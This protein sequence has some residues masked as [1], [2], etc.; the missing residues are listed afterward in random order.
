MPKQG[1]SKANEAHKKSVKIP[2]G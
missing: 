2:K 1:V